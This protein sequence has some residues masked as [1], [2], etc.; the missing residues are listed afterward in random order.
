MMAS[1][2]LTSASNHSL[3]IMTMKK[4]I[5][6]PS[7]I[8]ALSSLSSATLDKNLPPEKP[9]IARQSSLKATV[10]TNIDDT[11]EIEREITSEPKPPSTA[12]LSLVGLAL[13]LRRRH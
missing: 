13:I 5:I 12:L 11:S 4:I 9:E 7:A 6:T 2:L 3:S 1:I 8:V 10:F